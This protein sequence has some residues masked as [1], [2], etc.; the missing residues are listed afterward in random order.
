M[1]GLD[2]FYDVT[3]SPYVWDG[4]HCRRLWPDRCTCTQWCEGDDCGDVY[5][6]ERE[7]V[8]DHRQCRE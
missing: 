8:D 6:T 5:E 4:T 1:S 7:C 2:A 3:K